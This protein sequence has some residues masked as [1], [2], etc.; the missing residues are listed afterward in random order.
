MPWGGMFCAPEDLAVI[1]Q[2]MLNRGELEGVRL[3]NS[4]TVEMATTN[5]LDDY[6]FLPEGI[7][8]SQPWGL[9][10]RMN[11]PGNAK[12][13]GDSLGRHVFGHTGATG[14]GS[15]TEWF[16][17]ST[18]YCHPFPGTLAVG[19]TVQHHCRGI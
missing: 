13:F 16:L 5:R 8:R 11:H 4:E 1:C 2:W 18:D 14:D 7:R 15:Q 6:P 9:G 17:H 12:S 3:L 10:W 19:P